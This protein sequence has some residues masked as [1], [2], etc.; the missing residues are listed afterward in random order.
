MR[1]LL[2]FMTVTYRLLIV[3][4]YDQ[5]HPHSSELLQPVFTSM[6]GSCKAVE[7]IDDKL[8]AH[9]QKIKELP[10][11]RRCHKWLVTIRLKN[12][13]GPIFGLL[14]CF[15]L[16]IGILV[17]YKTVEIAD[18]MQLFAH[19]TSLSVS[20]EQAVSSNAIMRLKDLCL[21]FLEQLLDKSN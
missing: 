18:T 8:I 15:S 16:Y 2:F 10:T 21:F 11:G 1:I 4:G 19:H 14:E 12:S 3:R 13:S 7:V 6:L 5:C 20:D 9:I 17:M